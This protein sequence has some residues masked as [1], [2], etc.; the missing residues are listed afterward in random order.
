[1]AADNVH[2]AVAAVN[3]A[4]AAAAP[5][6]GKLQTPDVAAA[7]LQPQRLAWG[8]ESVLGTAKVVNI[9]SR[10]QNG[11]LKRLMCSIAFADALQAAIS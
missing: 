5:A 10:S 7:A 3:L 6:P 1:M 11:K 9:A 8:S 2:G 4:A